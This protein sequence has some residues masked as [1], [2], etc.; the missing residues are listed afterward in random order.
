MGAL[1]GL[2]GSTANRGDVMAEARLKSGLWVRAQLRMCDLAGRACTVLRHGD[3]DAGT[4]ILKLL[5]ADGL[6]RVLAQTTVPDGGLA[7][8]HPLGATPMPEAE[9]EAYIARTA[10]FDPDIWALEVI[11]RDGSFAFEGKILD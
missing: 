4:I 7:W 8:H 10:K 9:A 3:D 6:A 2:Q 11:D 1:Y 5:G